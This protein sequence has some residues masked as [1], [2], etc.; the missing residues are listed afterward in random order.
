MVNFGLTLGVKNR[1]N[2]PRKAQKKRLHET[3][4]ADLK[5]C[6]S[7]SNQGHKDFA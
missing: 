1:E 3:V 2:Q 7:E 4:D 6:H 5:W